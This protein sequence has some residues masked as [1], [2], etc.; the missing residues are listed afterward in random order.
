MGRT[1]K[2]IGYV[3]K[4]VNEASGSRIALSLLYNIWVRFV[5]LVFALLLPRYLLNAY[6]RRADY[7]EVIGVLLLLWLTQIGYSLCSNYYNQVYRPVSD[8][9]IYLH[10]QKRIFIKALSI[11]LCNLDH[12]EYYNDFTKAN[13]EAKM[14]VIETMDDLLRLILDT[15]AL[16]VLLYVIGNIHKAFILISAFPVIVN[17]L[18]G[19]MLDPLVFQNEMEALKA[20]RKAECVNR[21]FFLKQY[22]KEIRISNIKNVLFRQFSEAIDQTVSIHKQYGRKIAAIKVI[23][24]LSNDI[25]CCLASAAAGLRMMQSKSIL[26]G[27]FVLVFS[28]LS[29]FTGYISA[30]MNDIFAIYRARNYIDNLLRFMPDEQEKEAADSSRLPFHNL[31]FC[32]VSFRYGNSGEDVLKDLSFKVSEGEKIAIVGNNGAGKSTLVKLLMR[33]YEEGE[34]R[35]LLN[36]EPAGDYSEEQ[37]RAMFSCV[38]QDYALFGCTIGEN[39]LCREV[40]ENDEDVI[41]NA[42]EKSG[43]DE[44]MR[45]GNMTIDSVVT[46][47]FDDNG[48]VFSGGQL[49]KLAIARAIANNGRIIVMDEPSS[50]LDP[51][52]EQKMFQRLNELSADR[53]LIYITHRI[54]AAVNADKIYFMEQGRIC[55]SG[56][57]EELLKLNRK[58]AAMYRMQSNNYR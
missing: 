13:E 55:E 19:R 44:D 56:S 42:L 39:I 51:L 52:A 14:R 2:N 17:I 37:Y 34:G 28:S 46:K 5:D 35:I 24:F 1:V 8:E 22:S 9:K 49:Q 54:S 53:T 57:H 6:E 41:R 48:V 15:A 43:L 25:L 11:P 40:L 47:E 36:G 20:R 12:S 18:C 7:L 26:L 27:D 38:F 32:N 33:M 3:L 45:Y 58:Y 30:C 10:V 29:T 31:E 4:T 23:R 16:S 21:T 50:A